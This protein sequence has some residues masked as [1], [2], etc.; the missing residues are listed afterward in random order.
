M[1]CSFIHIVQIV[2]NQCKLW[3]SIANAN[4]VKKPNCCFKVIMEIS[5]AP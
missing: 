5:L 3:F 2:D 1:I 4:Y